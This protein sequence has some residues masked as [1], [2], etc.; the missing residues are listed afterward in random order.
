MDPQL[1]FNNESID[2]IYFSAYKDYLTIDTINEQR[3]KNKF[4]EQ[5]SKFPKKSSDRLT[6]QKVDI[7]N[8]ERGIVFPLINKYFGKQSSS[9]SQLVDNDLPDVP[10]EE[11]FSGT[12]RAMQ[13]LET[14]HML[15]KQYQDWAGFSQNWLVNLLK[16]STNLVVPFFSQLKIEIMK[17]VDTFSTV[18]TFFMDLQTLAGYVPMKYRKMS[19]DPVAWLTNDVDSLYDRDWWADAFART[20]KSNFNEPKTSFLTMEEFIH[21]PWLWATEGATAYSKATLDGETVRTKFGAAIS[22]TADD[23]MSMVYTPDEGDY[24]RRIGVFIK[25]DE[26]GYKRRLIANVPL[27]QYILAA[28]IRY[29]LEYFNGLN[30][31]Y[32]KLSPSIVEKLTVVGYLRQSVNMT[33]VDESAYDYHFTRSTWLGFIQFIKTVVPED[34]SSLFCQMFENTDWVQGQETGQWRKGMP[35]GLALTSYLNSWVNYIKQTTIAPGLI[36]WAAGDDSLI[37]GPDLDLTEL[38][39]SY[40]KF[41]ADVNAYKNWKSRKYAEYLK[42]VYYTQGVT[43]YPARIF[44]SL[45]WQGAEFAVE[46]NSKLSELAEL[47]KQLFDRFQLRFEENIVARDLARA[48]S[49]KINN[50]NK[51]T[52]RKYLHSPKAYGGFGFL[53]YNDIIFDWKTVEPREKQQYQNITIRMPPVV[54]SYKS[55]FTL[56]L[57][58]RPIRTG[59]SVYTG[60]P[61]ILPKITNMYEW[62]R[63]LNREDLPVR[64]KYSRFVTELIPLPT[65]EGVSTSIVSELA[66]QLRFNV[67][68]NLR[69]NADIQ[70]DRMVMAS[71]LLA[72]TVSN[73]MFTYGLRSLQ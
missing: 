54:V 49:K 72:R 73:L 45:T 13:W 35:S 37:V 10:W 31:T 66:R 56:T 28:Y 68:P 36:N 48:V 18:F 29:V 42:N 55:V 44:A 58:N 22:L 63:R 47:W 61:F 53:P 33:P 14:P 65:I 32:M 17:Q 46:P 12:R 50:F 5:T 34:A 67:Y 70:Q 16:E 19:D 24:D 7:Y 38:S 39:E 69:G 23:L 40:S 57:R 64:G 51:D 71:L 43:G 9:R 52:A 27:G 30:P 26:I 62:E 25:P 15:V 8:I 60:D 11:T 2:N 6:Q 4:N 1:R 3:N 21:S 20:F 59:V 41:G